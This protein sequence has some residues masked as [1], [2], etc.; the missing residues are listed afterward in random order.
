MRTFFIIF[1]GGG[2][3]S[4]IRYMLSNQVDSKFSFSFPLGIFIVNL[5]GCF[6]IGFF[7][8]YLENHRSLASEWKILLTTGFCGGFTTFSTFSADN[9]RLMQNGNLIPFMLNI[10]GSVIVGFFAVYLGQMLGKCM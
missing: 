10:M 2:L 5:I 1:L 8:A 4:A 9:L 7:L 6:L 3:G